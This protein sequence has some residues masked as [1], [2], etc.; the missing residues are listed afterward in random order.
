M[1][2]MGVMLRSTGTGRSIGDVG[3]LM[4]DEICM[5]DLSLVGGIEWNEAERV[6]RAL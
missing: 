5:E 1:L 6:L 3:V 2:C 4:T